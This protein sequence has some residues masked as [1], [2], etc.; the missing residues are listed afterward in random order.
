M[1]DTS[2]VSLAVQVEGFWKGFRV[3]SH[4]DVQVY[5]EIY[6][7]PDTAYTKVDLWRWNDAVFVGRWCSGLNNVKS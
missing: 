1:K 4:S 5:Q 3:S 2:C 7:G 6:N